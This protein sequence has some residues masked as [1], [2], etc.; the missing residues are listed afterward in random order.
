MARVT[1]SYGATDGGEVVERI[2]YRLVTYDFDLDDGPSQPIEP[3]QSVDVQIEPGSQ[4]LIELIEESADS[5][6][7][8][9][10]DEDL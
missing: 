1:I 10:E 5:N 8:L 7:D 3:G 9:F 4:L 6:A 2:G